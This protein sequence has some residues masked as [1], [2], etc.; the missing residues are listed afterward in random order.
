MIYVDVSVAGFV[1]ILAAVTSLVFE[2]F[3]KVKQWF[4]TKTPEQKRAVNA[5]ALFVIVAVVFA[6]GCLNLFQS[7]SLFCDAQGAFQ[8]VVIYLQAI[9]VNQGVHKLFKRA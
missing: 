6:G 3:P 7:E 5:F 9:A 1:A 8:M 4:E 2:F